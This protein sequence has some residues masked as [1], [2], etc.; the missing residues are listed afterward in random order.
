M[1]IPY[2]PHAGARYPSF[3]SRLE[4]VIGYDLNGWILDDLV[5]SCWFQGIT[6]VVESRS[7][8]FSDD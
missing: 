7:N 5:L 6:T 8:F 3:A 4:K 2:T 1:T